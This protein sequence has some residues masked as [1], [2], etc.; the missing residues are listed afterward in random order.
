MT[1]EERLRLT[2]A[3]IEAQNG[4]VTAPP[5]LAIRPEEIPD[6]PPTPATPTRHLLLITPEDV[7]WMKSVNEVMKGN[8]VGDI[9]KY[10]GTYRINYKPTQPGMYMMN[11]KIAD[12]D[13]PGSPFQIRVTEF[14]S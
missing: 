3:D 2:T 10:N 7:K 9:G 6:A 13:I 8:E 12:V 1:D 14:L 11:I 4:R 5:V